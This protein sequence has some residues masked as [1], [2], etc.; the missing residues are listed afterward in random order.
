MNT[1]SAIQAEVQSACADHTRRVLLVEDSRAIAPMLT[2]SIDSL[3]GIVCG[4]AS[5]LGEARRLLARAGADSDFVTV[6]DLSLPDPPNA[7]VIDLV[8]Q[9]GVPIIVLTANVDL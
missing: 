1:L 7:E 5:S 9:A 4:R 2:A 8:Q 3:Q 6:L